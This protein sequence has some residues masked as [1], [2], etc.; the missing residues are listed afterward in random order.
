MLCW[1]L[2]NTY[3]LCQAWLPTLKKFFFNVYFYFWRSEKQS[4]IGGGTER[5]GETQHL[6][7]TPGSELSAQSPTQG[8]NPRSWSEPKSIIQPTEPPRCPSKQWKYINT[9]TQWTSLWRRYFSCLHV[10]HKAT[11][12]QRVQVICPRWHSSKWQN[13]N[14][15]KAV[16]RVHT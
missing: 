6:K 11:E 12:T 8:S 10:T 14:V 9:F 3:H 1:H 16:S 2:L 7:Q 5:E 4:V 15:N 13:R